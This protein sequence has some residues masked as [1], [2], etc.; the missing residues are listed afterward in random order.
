[1]TSP[2]HRVGQFWRHASARVATNEAIAADA[3]LGSELAPLFRRLPVNDQR[4]GLDV[5][6]TVGRLYPNPDRLLQQAAL[7]HDVGKAE[8]R[9][10][11]I[12]RSL[13]A[14]L[15]AVSPATL[16]GLMRARPGFGRRYSAYRDHANIGAE[17]L[18][19]AG[20]LDLASVVQEH[21]APAPKSEVTERL[22]RADRRN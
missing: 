8:T 14:F 21:H 10:S 18:R 15:E 13:A 4:H 20:A 11:V 7:L 22:Q 16:N 3:I 5:L 1:M 9:F 19:A 6:A 12:E 17:R 2:L